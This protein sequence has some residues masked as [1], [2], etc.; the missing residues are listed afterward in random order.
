M[1]ISEYNLT[2]VIL[3]I[4]KIKT[5]HYINIYIFTLNSYTLNELIETTTNY[6]FIFI[7]LSYFMFIV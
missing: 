6:L 4:N 1:V 7:N 5:H 3:L 2:N